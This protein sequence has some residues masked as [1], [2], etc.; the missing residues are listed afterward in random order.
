MSTSGTL[1]LAISD[2]WRGFDPLDSFLGR[3]LASRWQ[4]EFDDDARLLVYGPYGGRHVRRRATKVLISAEPLALPPRRE[5]DY[6]LS[7]HVVAEDDHHARVL[8][9]AMMVLEH[10]EDARKF[11]SPSFDAWTKRPFF[12]NFIY[13]NDGP[14]ERREFFAALSRRRFVHSP[15]EVETNTDPIPGGRFANDWWPQKV[16]Y[17][18]QFRFSIAFESIALPGYTSEK[19][20][21]AMLAGTIPIYWGNPNVGVDVDPATFVDASSFSTWEELADHVI[22]L[23]DHP[24]LARPLIEHRRP[25]L[26]ELDETKRS[27][28]VLFERAEADHGFA[29]RVRRAMRPWLLYAAMVRPLSARARRKLLRT[30]KSFQRELERMRRRTT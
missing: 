8:P 17:Q 7:W 16:R 23:D 20:V 28:V 2:F 30:T 15:G 13:S 6:S 10:E 21:D 26:S 3:T 18:E 27:I 9:A 22:L 11:T 12:C 25:L 14:T 4:L 1:S 24:E 5:Y 19:I 29:S